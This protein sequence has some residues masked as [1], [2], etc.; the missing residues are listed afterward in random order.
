M[1]VTIPERRQEITKRTGRKVQIPQVYKARKLAKRADAI[2]TDLDHCTKFYFDPDG[3][4]V[5]QHAKNTYNYLHTHC[6]DLLLDVRLML[7]EVE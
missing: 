6:G 1:P 2:Y 7:S 3:P 4:R 5:V